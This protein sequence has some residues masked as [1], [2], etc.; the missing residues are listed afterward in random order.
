MLSVHVF[1]RTW[2][3]LG[4]FLMMPS[5]PLDSTLTSPLAAAIHTAG[6]VAAVGATIASTLEGVSVRATKPTE[7]TLAD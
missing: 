3:N 4:R 7:V 5:V 1:V 6:S 2:T